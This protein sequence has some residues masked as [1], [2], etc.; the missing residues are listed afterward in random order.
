MTGE[1]AEPP[2]GDLRFDGL[3]IRPRLRLVERDGV[4]IALSANEFDLLYFLASHPRQVFTREELLNRVW[5]YA[6]VGD[7]RTVTVQMARLRKKVET[8]PA[9]PR[10]LRTVWRV[11]YKFMP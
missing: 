8:D 10:H 4:S 7:T 2:Q 9:N 3:F 1:A 6:Y 5:L 11:G